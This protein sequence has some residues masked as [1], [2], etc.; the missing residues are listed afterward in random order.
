MRRLPLLFIAVASAIA[1]SAAPA[2]AAGDNTLASS[3]PTAGETVT[4]APT[5]LQLKFTLPVG[6]AEIA[7]QMGLSLACES[8][9]TNL[10]PPQLSA[11]GVTISAALTQVPQNGSCVVNWSLPDGSVGSFN[12][13]AQTQVTTSVPVTVPGAPATTV[14][15]DGTAIEVVA[16]R[17]G[18][19]IGLMK[20]IVFFAVCALFG[21]LMFIK[22]VWPEGVEYGITEKYFRQISII[23]GAA[24]FVLIILMTARQSGDGLASSISPTSWGPLFETNEGR[25]VFVRLLVVGVL[26]YYA[27]ITERILEP[28]NV[29]PTTVLLAL[30]MISY[31]FDRATG[32][33]VVLGIVVAILHMAFIA[34]WVGSISIIWRVIL[35][36]PGNSD[37]VDALRGWARL[38]T[39]LTI[40][41]VLTGVFQVWRIDGISLINSGHGRLVLFKVLLVGAMLFV[42]A[43]VRQ[44]ILRGMQ[45]AKSLN[46]KVVYRLKRPV[47]IEMSLSIVVLAASSWLMAMRPPYVLSRETGPRVEYAIVQDMTAKDDF[48]VRL[49]ITPGD[50]GAN[51]IL[52]ELF[53]PSRIQNF[54]MTLV[55]TN[56]NFPGYTINVPIT[57]PGGALLAQDAGLL[58]RAPGEWTATVTGVTTIGELPPMS[59]TFIIADGTT[60]TTQPKQGLEKS[61][62]TIAATTTTTS[63]APAPAT[64]T[65]V[66]APIV[67]TTA[68]P[69]AG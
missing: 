26:G 19:P 2:Q 33:A 27:W 46:E 38:A 41:I 10:G 5:Q 58:L 1:F 7:S 3:S 29:V 50:V 22:L 69:A 17:L 51:R 31:G 67:T 57:R 59:T 8:K 56:P 42:S 25:A 63:V 18:G 34:M 53:G 16:P 15:I 65:T 30:M 11:D 52:I 60:V 12:F 14:P 9:L 49:S 47:G 61:T 37:L 55:P 4:L 45:R 28:T 68:V 48:H 23:A 13:T 39:P 32:R 35:H 21:G 62:T 24:I 40:G 44:F 43:A 64:S 36:G 6:G 66:P 20:L 54:K